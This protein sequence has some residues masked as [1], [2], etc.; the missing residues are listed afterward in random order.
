MLII[1]KR[2]SNRITWSDDIFF[3]QKVKGQLHCD[4]I[5]SWKNTFVHYLLI[6]TPV[7]WVHPLHFLSLDDNQ[8]RKRHVPLV[9]H[10]KFTGFADTDL[11]VI[12]VAPCD[13]ALDQSSVLLC[14]KSL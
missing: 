1:P 2:V 9:V 4:N 7:Y 11:Q 6:W 12:V 14:K 10:H 3:T 8:D 5:M 13:E